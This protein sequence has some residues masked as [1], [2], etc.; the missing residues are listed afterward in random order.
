MA[1]GDPQNYSNHSLTAAFDVSFR[2]GVSSSGGSWTFSARVPPCS[3]YADDAITLERNDDGRY[4]VGTCRKCG[5]IVRIRYEPEVEFESELAWV[6]ENPTIENL[7]W[8]HSVL[9]PLVREL[10]AYKDLSEKM[11]VEILERTIAGR[12]DIGPQCSALVAQLRENLALPG[13]GTS[14]T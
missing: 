3:C 14:D 11:L 10:Q 12:M 9:V 13:A 4:L 5:E 8:L 1:A 6:F 7:A 2:Q